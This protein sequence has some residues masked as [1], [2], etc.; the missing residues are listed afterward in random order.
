MLNLQL[1]FW[2]A[3]EL[4]RHQSVS[5]RLWPSAIASSLSN[6]KVMYLYCEDESHLSRWN[7]LAEPQQVEFSAIELSSRIDLKITF[8][9]M[10]V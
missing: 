7:G 1:L 4:Q 3:E 6:Y 8:D 2:T 9:K 5:Q 10:H